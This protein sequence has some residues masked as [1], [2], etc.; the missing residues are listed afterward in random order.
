MVRGLRTTT[1]PKVAEQAVEVEV[2]TNEMVTTSSV[3]VATVSATQKL[4]MASF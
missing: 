2:V 3:P 1:S 4:V